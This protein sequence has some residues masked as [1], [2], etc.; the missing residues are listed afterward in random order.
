MID[1]LLVFMGSSIG[2]MILAAI[3]VA[4]V[5]AMFHKFNV[6]RK[7]QKVV[8]E[9]AMLVESV[10]PEGLIMDRFLDRFI[11][12][13]KRNY[14]EEPPKKVRQKALKSVAKLKMR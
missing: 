9:T 12:L 14:D 6:D 5:F 1:I 4:I 8:L 7:V 11:E 2:I 13:Y 10:T 3:A